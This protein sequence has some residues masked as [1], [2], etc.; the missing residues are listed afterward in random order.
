MRIAALFNPKARKW[1]KGRK[2][3][4]HRLQQALPAGEKIIWIHCASLGEFEQ[5]RPVMERLKTEFPRY[6]ILLTFFSPSGYE[7]QKNYAGADWI[8]Y[9]PMDGPLNAKKF[10]EI[11]RPSLVIFVKYEFW[12]YYLKKFKYRQVPLLLISAFFRKDMASFK[13]YGGLQQKMISRFDRIFVQ[14]QSSKKLLDEMGLDK[15]VTI[16]G[17]T[18]FDR[19]ISIADKA[20][21]LPF[22]EKFIDG[23]QAIVAGSTW[24]EDD[25]ILQKTM[26]LVNDDELKLIIAPHEINKKQLDR[27]LELFPGAILYSDYAQ[28]LP[29]RQAGN[30][31][32]ID[33]IGMLSR[34]YKYAFITYVGGGFIKSGIHNVLEPAVYHK[35]VTWGPFYKKYYE[36]IEL[37]NAKGGFVVNDEAELANCWK[38][39][40]GSS[41]DY[42]HAAAAAGNYVKENA[43]ATRIIIKYIQE[44]RLLTS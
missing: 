23:K 25:I 1:L 9:M 29:D 24:P 18:R 11:V 27:T 35:P 15:I 8:F 12:Y 33:N 37:E 2:D 41:I 28:S 16:S 43:G 42:T 39:L 5:G 3:I 38:K 13:W 6:K 7:A 17:D 30:I 34:L 14:N 32:V 21:P 40:I 36:A 10:L 31:L 22:I 19:V 44:N 4:F 26:S 20:E